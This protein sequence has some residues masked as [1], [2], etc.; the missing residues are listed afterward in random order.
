MLLRVSLLLPLLAVPS[1]DAVDVTVLSDRWILVHVDEG[2]VVHHVAG[3]K[4]SHEKVVSTPLDVDR[5]GKP[6]SWRLSSADDPAYAAGRAPLRVGRKSKGTDFAWF[7]DRW[8]NGRAVNDRPDHAKEHWLYLETP[9][10][11]KPGCTYKV[12]MEGIEGTVSFDVTTSR[13]EAV[14]VNLVGYPANSPVKYGYVHQWMGD[15]GG[16]GSATRPGP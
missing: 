14:H 5:A 1:F 12:S 6:A 2:H 10:A 9:S 8:A 13:S 11:L 15:A 3:Q 16:F 7:T 4:R